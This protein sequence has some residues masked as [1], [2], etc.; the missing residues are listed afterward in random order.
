MMGRSLPQMAGGHNA[1]VAAETR[2]RI[3]IVDDCAAV[4]TSYSY[5]FTRAGWHVEVADGGEDALAVIAAQKLEAVL[6]DVFM[7]QMDGVEVL[8][9][10]RAAR[11]HIAIIAV[12]GTVAGTYDILPLMQKLG[13]DAAVS[14]T[15]DASELVRIVKSCVEARMTTAPAP[16]RNDRM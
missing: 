6:L 8:L 13:A 9:S 11:A 14:K 12:S 7:P 2:P 5:I 1:V 15:V 10:T 3:L 16:A 4:R